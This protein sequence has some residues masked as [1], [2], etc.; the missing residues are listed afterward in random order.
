MLDD[1]ML[2]FLFLDYHF[3]MNRQEYCKMTYVWQQYNATAQSLKK[4]CLF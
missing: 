1:N 2:A 4:S 3:N